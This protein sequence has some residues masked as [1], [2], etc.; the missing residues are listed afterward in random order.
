M[1]QALQAVADEFEPPIAS[2]FAYCSEQQNL[3]VATETALRELARRT[4]LLEIKLFVLALLVQQ[5]TGGNLAE[6]LDKLAS[7]VRERFR[8]RGKIRTLTAE[9]RMQAVVLLV[10]APAMFLLILCLN[11]RYAHVLLDH[12]SLP[13]GALICEA[14]GALWI[15][16]IVNFDF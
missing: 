7:V 14:I 8:I 10:L 9:G 11:R 2:E 1:A 3:G 12:P 6:L 13:V 5:Q 15:R 16:R 4:G